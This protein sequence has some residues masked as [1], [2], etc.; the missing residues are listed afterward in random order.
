MTQTAAAPAAI[1]PLSA[2][3]AGANADNDPAHH[4]P[5]GGFVD[6]ETAAASTDHRDLRLWLRLLT[7]TTLVETE[8][9]A[10]LRIA[11]D[12]TLPRFDFMAALHKADGPLTMGDLSRRM[13]VSNG[14]VTGVTERLAAEGLV[15]RF[16]SAEDKRTQYVELTREGRAYFEQMAALHEQWVSS[17]FADL[18]DGEVE[19]L[20]GLLA[21][22]KSSVR[23]N[24]ARSAADTPPGHNPP[25]DPST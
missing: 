12:T 15:H 18:S 20:M 6:H 25:G 24:L 9:R 8:I 2:D 23:R 19:V 16:R 7:C 21:R 13:M 1:L 3:S 17:A 11:F 5:A 4:D 22:V 14:N 10:N